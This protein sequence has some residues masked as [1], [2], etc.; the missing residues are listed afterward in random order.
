[1]ASTGEGPSL[2]DKPVRKVRLSPAMDPEPATS[3]R[4]N[5]R[6]DHP[7]TQNC[8]GGNL[9]E[10][11]RSI[12]AISPGEMAAYAVLFIVLLIAVTS[13]GLSMR[14]FAPPDLR[15]TRSIP[16]SRTCGKPVLPLS[17]SL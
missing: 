9:K 4:N 15:L 2:N 11:R 7:E 6:K 17:L 14:C 8:G 12:P 16:F 3:R 1:M 5:C 10:P 13:Y